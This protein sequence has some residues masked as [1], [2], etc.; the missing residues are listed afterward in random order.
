MYTL[1]LPEDYIKPILPG[2][3]DWLTALR[4]GEYKQGYDMLCRME[5]RE[6]TYCCLGVL[7]KINGRMSTMDTIRVNGYICLASVDGD[8]FS[9][10]SNAPYYSVLDTEGQFPAD[11]EVR[12]D[13]MMLLSLSGVNDSHKCSFAEMADIIEKIWDCQ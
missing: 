12:V 6:Y 2:G 11:V 5:S 1:T 10:H 8:V 3:R 4:S 7:E 13:D 9:I